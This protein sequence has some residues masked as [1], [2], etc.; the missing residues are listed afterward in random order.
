VCGSTDISWNV[1]TVQY[2]AVC[3][4]IVQFGGILQAVLADSGELELQTGF[5]DSFQRLISL[6]IH[7][8]FSVIG[9][10][11]MYGCKLSSSSSVVK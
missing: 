5:T 1:F 10:S 7:Y 8:N 6:R 4:L 2:N 11:T 9:Y 3:C